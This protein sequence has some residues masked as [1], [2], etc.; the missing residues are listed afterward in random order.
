MKSPELSLN[1]LRTKSRAEATTLAQE[2]EALNQE[3]REMQD[4]AVREIEA[5]QDLSAPV[6][7]VDGKWHEGVMGIIAGR[8]L[9][10]YQKPAFALTEVEDGVLKGSGRSFGDFSLAEALQHCKKLLINGGGHALACGV[11]LKRDQLEMFRKQMTKYY[12]SLNLQ[13]QLRFLEQI[14]DLKV[15]DLSELDETLYDEISLL[16]PFGDGNTEPIFETTATV[17]GRRVLKEKHLSVQLRDKK[18]NEMKM[19][20]FSAPADWLAVETGQCLNVQFTLTKNEWRGATKIEG[21]LCG[22]HRVE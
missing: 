22:L 7:I 13:D 19:M 17:V 6:L 14:A 4:V 18:G 12:L 16:E 10:L 21:Q 15:D 8:L 2:L 9:E 20:A 11:S 5:Q 3:R 1:L